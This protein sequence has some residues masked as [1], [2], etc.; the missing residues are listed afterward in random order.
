MIATWSPRVAR[1]LSRQLA[2]AFS[3]PSSY[4]LVSTLPVKLVFLILVGNLIHSSRFACSAQNPSGSR[5]ARSYM[6]RYCSALTSAWAATS[7]LTG[8]SC[9]SWWISFMLA[10]P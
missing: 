1:C 10:S 5:S 8:I 2:E 9:F 3:V 7:G 4:H 6:A